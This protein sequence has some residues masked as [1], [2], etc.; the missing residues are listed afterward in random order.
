M[1]FNNK[2]TLNIRDKLFACDINSMYDV[3]SPE[4][5][6]ETFEY[7][8]FELAPNYLSQDL[9]NLWHKSMKHIFK[10]CYFKYKDCL[11]LLKNTQIQGSKSGGDNCNL[12]L[13]IHEIRNIN[14]IKTYT[15]IMLRY[16]DDIFGISRINIMNKNECKN[17]IINKIYPQFDFEYDINNEVEICDIKVHIDYNNF[18]LSTTTLN[19]V[20]KITSFVNKSS[21]INQSS[22]NGIFKTLQMRYIIIDDDILKYKYTKGRICNILIK[23][24]EWNPVDIRLC[25]HL[26][27]SKRMKFINKYLDLKQIKYQEY[28]KMKKIYLF[29]NKWWNNDNSN[30]INTYITYQKTLI[31]EKK[32]NKII[33]DSYNLLNE[34]IKNNY[35]IKLYYKYQQ[36]IGKLIK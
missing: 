8:I 17:K 12:Y 18:K 6:M 26:S 28:I 2:N 13:I 9:I 20:N 29:D 32:I 24:N 1:E 19:N 3:I 21:N 10:F 11:Y 33:Y 4:M 25:E 5:V 22:I 31:N 23:H 15:K 34:N 16:K 14:K 35:N 36:P 27:Y 7:A 30:N